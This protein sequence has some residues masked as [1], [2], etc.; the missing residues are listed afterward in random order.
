M[1]ISSGC[2][3]LALLGWLSM[4]HAQDKPAHAATAMQDYVTCAVYFRMV[5]GAIEANAG[6]DS[7]LADLPK[8]K[9]SDLSDAA[10]S[11]AAKAFGDAHAEAKFEAAWRKTLARMT[12]EINRNYRNITQLRVRYGDHCGRL[13]KSLNQGGP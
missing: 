7:V 3:A 2:I 4:A 9:M 6:Q 11:S 8:G 5:A 1:K 12:D 13:Y 10:R